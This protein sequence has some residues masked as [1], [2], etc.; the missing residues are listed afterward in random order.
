MTKL[1]HLKES[2]LTRAASATIGR[3]RSTGVLAVAVLVLAAVFTSGAVAANHRGP[4][5]RMG[6][7]RPDV[8]SAVR[9]ALLNPTRYFKRPKLRHGVLSVIGTARG[10]R[11]ALRLKSGRP[12]LLQV[13]VGDDGSAEFSFMRRKVARIIVDARAGDDL[14]RIDETNG[15]F[16]DTIE[17]AIDGGAGNDTLLGGSGAERLLGSDGNDS[18]DGNKGN[19]L[20]L[21]GAGDD[22]FVWDPGDGS[23]VVEG[24]DGADTMV[25]NGANIAD[26][27]ELSGNGSRLRFFRNPGMITM[28]TAGVEQ[29]DF[30]A[31]GGADL[32]TVNDL[33]GT[34]VQRLNVELE[35]TPG[36]AAG[37]GQLDRV[38]VNGTN[39]NDTIDVSGDASGV[40]VAGLRVR[41]AIRHQEPSDELVING[42]AGDDV[43]SAAA[44][45]AQAITLTVDGGEG[46]DTLAGGRGVE[47]LLGSN[48]DDSID[49]NG[50]NDVALM[51]AGDDVFVWDPGD[52]SDVVEGQDGADTMVFN[53]ANIADQVE[54]SGNGSRLRF[55]RN[56]GM[57]TMDTAGVE[58]VDF[59]ALGGADTV[60][61]NDLTGTGVMSVSA[62]LGTGDGQ[63][64]RV[65]VNGTAG[66]DAIDVSGDAGEVKVSGLAATVAVFSS[67]FANDQ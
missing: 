12:T 28:D 3:L 65:V 53:G 6:S 20:A 41:V 64:D 31:L 32:V 7:A 63:S 59:N 57:I 54:L 8:I 43:I 14:V 33:S 51:G 34:D 24:Q 17:T 67:E 4:A 49:G 11:I 26:Q 38:V 39:R 27:V 40:A 46:A 62:E 44:L 15:V 29:V 36:G 60:I 22:V 19:D 9:T 25:F 58:Q 61:V 66:N 50:G 13:D 16:T 42:L 47:R 2:R 35:G 1:S 45:A 21:M 23:D 37:D 56:P 48:G 5:L 10:E 18:I 55:F 52:G 30:N